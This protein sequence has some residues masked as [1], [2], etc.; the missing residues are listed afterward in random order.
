MTDSEHVQITRE[1][2]AP[3]ED[4]FR[5][6]TDPDEVAQWYGP[7]SMTIP[8]E[9]V[10]IQARVG[11]RWEVTMVPKAGG[12][13]F[14]IGYEI[15]ELVEPDLLVMRSDPTPGL[16][17]GTTIRIELH[18]LGARTRM[19]LRDGPMPAGGRPGAEAGY[20]AALDQLTAHLSKERTADSA[21]IG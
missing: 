20:A 18:D 13:G 6:W 4:V 3:R 17:E 16:P 19:I 10:R 15:V 8:R 7:A 5:A 9:S 14:A 2:E 11:G 1:L 21:S 12:D